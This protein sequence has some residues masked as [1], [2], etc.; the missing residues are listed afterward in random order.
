MKQGH[1]MEQASLTSGRK[2]SRNTITVQFT[3]DPQTR[4]LISKIVLRAKGL[5]LINRR[6]SGQTC[7]MDVN[8]V[9]SNGNP[10][11]LADLLAADDFNFMHDICG[12]AR[13]LDRDTGK[14]GDFF[15]PR[16][17]RRGR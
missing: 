11:R 3:H 2:S 5:G 4:E 8:A 10:L 9:H 6:Y 1:I 17:S 15:S 13:H 16:F 14:L 7:S 12:I